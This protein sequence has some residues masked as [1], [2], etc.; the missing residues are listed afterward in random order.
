MFWPC[1]A[2]TKLLHVCESYESV[3]KC[4]DFK[5]FNYNAFS[6]SWFSRG[7]NSFFRRHLGYDI[8][9]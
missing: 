3:R 7:V 4:N 2:T 1:H 9:Q 6:E 5:K 8:L